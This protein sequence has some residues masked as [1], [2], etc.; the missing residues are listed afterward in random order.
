MTQCVEGIH[1][2]IDYVKN[3]EKVVYL[4]RE[5]RLQIV[6]ASTEDVETLESL[7]NWL[8]YSLNRMSI[9]EVKMISYGCYNHM[10]GNKMGK[11]D[12]ITSHFYSV[13]LHTPTP[14]HL[15][16]PVKLNPCFCNYF[17][18][19]LRLIDYRELCFDYD[20]YCIVLNTTREAERYAMGPGLQA[21]A[22]PAPPILLD[23]SQ[24]DELLTIDSEFVHSQNTE[25]EDYMQELMHINNAAPAR[26]PVPE[27]DPIKIKI[28]LT[29]VNKNDLHTDLCSIC[30]CNKPFIY[31]KCKHAFC[32]CILTNTLEYNK[33]VCPYCRDGL[34]ELNIDNC[35]IYNTL[36]SV[37]MFLPKY[38]E[39]V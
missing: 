39:F 37:E 35:E 9:N 2:G 25:W 28:T 5:R 30:L 26:A 15:S 13:W 8:R 27:P 14:E 10:H 34:K 19:T 36:K 4:L 17:R 29:E 21:P 3:L 11:I 16:I 23:L 32:S 33:F 7:L 38:V 18:N 22:Q 1:K 12:E 20:N 6:D 24:E 31:T